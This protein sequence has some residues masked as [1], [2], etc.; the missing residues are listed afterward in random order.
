M[1]INNAPKFEHVVGSVYV[2][3]KKQD[4]DGMNTTGRS[5]H[6]RINQ[7]SSRHDANNTIL[8]PNSKMAKGNK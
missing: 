4:D 5:F 8:N 3:V 7:Y 6:P 2:K 1:R